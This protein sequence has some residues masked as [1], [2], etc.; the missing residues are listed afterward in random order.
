MKLSILVFLLFIFSKTVLASHTP[1]H[2]LEEIKNSFG[3]VPEFYQK[4]PK[5]GLPGAWDEM[6]TLQLNPN[7][8]IPGHYK[9]LIGL[10]V[11]AQIPCHY[12][13]YFH[14]NAAKLNGAGDREIDEAIVVASQARFWATIFNGFQIDFDDFKK[15]MD[16]I[17]SHL[18]EK[19]EPDYKAPNLPP[20]EITDAESVYKDIEREMGIVPTFIKKMPKASLP[21]AWKAFKGLEVNPKTAIPGK[22]KSLIS[23]GVASQIPCKYCIYWDT[24]M[25]K[26]GGA[27][28]QEI[29]E[30]IEMAATTR[31]WSTWL[32]GNLFNEKKFKEEADKIFSHIKK[33]KK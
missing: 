13:A 9:E 11:A 18:K 12:C 21:G 14:I 22:M 2:A 8:A 27:T 29:A 15:E 5:E 31:H 7:T 10:G 16:E 3:R 25:A 28:E 24:E 32:N 30:A 17:L 6:K 26:L 1:E 23:L 19:M 33:N 20:I 4:F